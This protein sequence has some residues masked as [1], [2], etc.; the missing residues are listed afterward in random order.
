MPAL[1]LG[2]TTLAN[3]ADARYG[4][5]FVDACR[6][7]FFSCGTARGLHY[8]FSPGQDP[9]VEFKEGMSL[10]LAETRLNKVG[11][12]TELAVVFNEYALHAG[13]GS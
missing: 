3:C 4:H 6:F 10:I 9:T 1:R 12:L 2:I 5:M 8:G 7:G 11:V 13:L